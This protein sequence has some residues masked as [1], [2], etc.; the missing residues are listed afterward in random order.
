MEIVRI[1]VVTLFVF[2]SSSA[3][4]SSLLSAKVD[5]LLL[6]S[7]SNG[8]EFV[9]EN[10]GDTVA[11]IIKIIPGCSCE[12]AEASKLVLN[13]NETTTIILRLH[14]NPSVGRHEAYVQTES[15]QILG[16]TVVVPDET[17]VAAPSSLHWRGGLIAS[18][19]IKIKAAF[20]FSAKDA[21]AAIV[22]DAFQMKIASNITEKDSMVVQVTPVTKKRKAVGYLAIAIHNKTGGGRI[23]VPLVVE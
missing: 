20:G 9:L 10:T 19:L 8:G 14:A 11:K 22:G 7:E 5:T 4:G 3:F 13:P 1:L 23:V 2:G 21:R 18:K 15:G 16:L 12:K 17:V 6:D